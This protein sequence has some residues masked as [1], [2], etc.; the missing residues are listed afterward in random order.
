LK[1]HGV[2]KE[3][4]EVPFVL[5]SRHLE[6]VSNDVSSCFAFGWPRGCSEF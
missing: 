5:E 3:K 4:A 2:D 1:L 6:K